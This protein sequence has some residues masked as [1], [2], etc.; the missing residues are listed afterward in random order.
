MKIE[1]LLLKHNK[2]MPLIE[3][4]G[5]CEMT[6]EESEIFGVANFVYH[7]FD[8]V[9][10]IL[11]DIEDTREEVNI[12]ENCIEKY[13]ILLNINQILMLSSVQMYFREGLT[14]KVYGSK[15]IEKGKFKRHTLYTFS[16]AK[17]KKLEKEEDGA[18]KIMN[19]RADFI[20]FVSAFQKK[21]KKM[22]LRRIDYRMQNALDLAMHGK[23]KSM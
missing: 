17:I 10:M 9:E 8:T 23:M 12:L 5:L 2:D 14:F 3:M 4:P 22:E 15:Q 13:G 11:E 7:S 21:Q 20:E 6:D 16:E 18:M 19:V 1:D